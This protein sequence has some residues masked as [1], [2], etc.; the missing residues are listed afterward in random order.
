V[1]TPN[2]SPVKALSDGVTVS[3]RLTPKASAD[4]IEGV[5]AAM[6]GAGELKARVTAAPERGKA[7][8]ALIRLLAKSWK[9]PK[10]S[11]SIAAGGKDRRKVI[12]V[13][14]DPGAL[15]A[16]LDRWLGEQRD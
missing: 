13:A 16:R 7:N 5:V 14:G 3:V 11:L 15:A 8:T 9:L 2:P 10:S 1:T 12:H 4:R 6:D